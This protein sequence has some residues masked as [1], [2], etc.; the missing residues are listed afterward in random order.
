MNNYINERYDSIKDLVRKSRLINEQ[1]N[2]EK[3]GPVNV[4]KDIQAKIDDDKYETAVEKQKSGN[5]ETDFVQR[6]R[7]SGSILAIHGKTKAETEIT[8]DD[9]VAFQDTIDEFTEEVSDLV[10]FNQL[11]VYPNTVEWSGKIID[12][13]IEF[14]YTIGEDSG[15]YINSNMLKIDD[16]TL[17]MINK[18]K[19]FYEKFKSKWSKVVASRKIT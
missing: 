16:D 9:K 19:A 6:Y 15:I 2:A 13:D 7:I 11:N 8:S 4:A 12:H 10:D 14:I 5:E 17:E 1:L 3:L 18:L